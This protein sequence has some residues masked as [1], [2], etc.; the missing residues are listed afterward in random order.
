[1][2][3]NVFRWRNLSFSCQLLVLRELNA[4]VKIEQEMAPNLIQRG[5][6]SSLDNMKFA[7]IFGLGEECNNN[8]V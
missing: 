7:R 2:R 4:L 5:S 8:N 1:M 6:I 3:Y